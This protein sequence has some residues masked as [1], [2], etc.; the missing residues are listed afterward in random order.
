MRITGHA[1][2]RQQAAKG[3]EA[4]A[5]KLLL[6]PSAERPA[7]AARCCSSTGRASVS[8]RRHLGPQLLH[9]AAAARAGQGRAAPSRAP[10]APA[11]LPTQRKQQKSR[12]FRPGFPAAVHSF[13][14]ML[15]SASQLASV[16]PAVYP[17]S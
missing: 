9:A 16:R 10:A 14:F 2:Q 4:A 15:L 5:A 8:G 12:A 13:V 1:G 6:L 11:H 7:A 17:S 3:C